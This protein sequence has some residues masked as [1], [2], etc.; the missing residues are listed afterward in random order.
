MVEI[1]DILEDKDITISE[2]GGAALPLLSYF[3]FIFTMML[4]KTGGK[5]SLLET[6]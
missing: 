3:V 5:A 1:S 6:E 4:L 2:G